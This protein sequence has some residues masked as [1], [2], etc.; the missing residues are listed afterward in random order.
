MAKIN[1]WVWS[2]VEHVS[3]YSSCSSVRACEMSANKNKCYTASFKQNSWLQRSAE[4]EQMKRSIGWGKASVPRGRQGWS[5]NCYTYQEQGRSHGVLVK[6]V[7]QNLIISCW[8]GCSASA[9]MDAEFLGLY[10]KLRMCWFPTDQ[11]CT[12]DILNRM[13]DPIQ[14]QELKKK[15]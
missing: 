7:D 13:S 10:M 3:S 9:W 1:Y 15:N 12:K 11:V 14:Y 6:L 5:L 4:I 8:R 2:Q